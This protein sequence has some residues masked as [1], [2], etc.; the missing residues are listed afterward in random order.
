MIAQLSACFLITAMSI[1]QTSPP[2][3]T[4]RNKAEDR[5]TNVSRYK[6]GGFGPN[7][8]ATLGVKVIF[9]SGVSQ[10]VT[11][12]SFDTD[13]PASKAGIQMYDQILEVDGSPVGFIR[14]R[15]YELWPKYGRAGQNTTE[16][17]VSYE[18]DSGAR[19]YYYLP[20]ATANVTGVYP[21]NPLPPDFF[22]TPKKVTRDTAESREKNLARYVFGV[23]N[24]NKYS[25][26]EIGVS[27]SYPDEGG[28]KIE[29]VSGG[30]PAD[31][32]GLQ[33]GD[34]IL[35]VDGAPVGQ[36]GDRIYEVWKQYIYSK[37]GNVELLIGFSD[38][39]SGQPRYYYPR[40]QLDKRTVS[41]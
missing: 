2:K 5:A 6:L 38:E 30:G 17:L 31:K 13:S 35:E 1:G 14:E 8:S 4:S 11:V 34:Y 28:A 21:W 20:V 27:L 12:S 29:M 15:Y 37:N 3:P 9:P 7:A 26:Y 18:D 23:D 25:P 39:N 16:V 32:A 41:Q 24:F 10:G 33:V 36:F 22:T 19:R 40:V